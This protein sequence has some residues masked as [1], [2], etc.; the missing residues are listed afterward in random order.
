MVTPHT[1]G[2]KGAFRVANE[3]MEVDP[4]I[5]RSDSFLVGHTRSDGTFPT[6]LVAEKVV[7]LF[8]H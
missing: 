6:A 4:T 2:R 5:T 3:M 7:R 1:T 8:A